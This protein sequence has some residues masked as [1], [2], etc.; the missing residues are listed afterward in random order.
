MNN[1][2]CMVALKVQEIG[3]GAQCIETALNKEVLKGKGRK[4]KR[5]KKKEYFPGER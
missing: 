3:N 1:G 4:L 2:L 5:K